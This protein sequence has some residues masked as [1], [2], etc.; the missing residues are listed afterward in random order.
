MVQAQCS[1]YTQVTGTVT[2]PNGVPW[3][4]GT[5]TATLSP[6]SASPTCTNGSGV[7]VP[8]SAQIGPTP[9]GSDGSFSLSL[10]P[11]SIITPGSTQWAFTFN[12]SG[13]APPFGKGPQTFS[14]TVTISG[15]SQ[16]IT[17]QIT[18]APVPSLTNSAG[19]GSSGAPNQNLIYVSSNCGTPAAKNCFQT[20]W[21][22]QHRV[23]A[24]WSNGSTTVNCADCAFT[25]SDVGKRIAGFS[26]C[27]AS[28]GINA[29]NSLGSQAGT[30]ISSVNS[31]T[32]AVV[33]NAA[34][35]TVS[36]NGCLYWGHPDDVAL[37]AADAAAQSSTNCPAISLPAGI[38]VATQPHFFIQ[39]PAC[40]RSPDLVGNA[41]TSFGFTVSGQGMQ[42]TR[43]WLT[44][45]FNLSG[46]RSTGCFLPPQSTFDG[47][48]LTGGGL[49]GNGVATAGPLIQLSVNA[50]LVDFGCL[51]LYPR[52]LSVVGISAQSPEFHS[53]LINSQIDGCGALGLSDNGTV[54]VTNSSIEDSY[55]IQAEISPGA[56][57][58]GGVYQASPESQAVGQVVMNVGGT[59]Y[60]I[61]TY[62]NG[63]TGQLTGYQGTLAS[64][65]RCLGGCYFSTSANGSSQALRLDNTSTAVLFGTAMSSGGLALY[66]T[67][68]T[69]AITDLGGN[70]VSSGAISI[71]SGTQIN[72]DASIGGV[73]LTAT[74][75]TPSS[76]WG[77]T[78]AAGNGVSSASGSTRAEVFTI[79]A[80]GTPTAN[81]TVAIVFPKAFWAAPS[82]GCQAS[83]IGGTGVISDVLSNTATATGVTLTWEGTPVSG[84]TYI[85]SVRCSNP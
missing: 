45:D 76:G 61:Q 24:T 56:A 12:I 66:T 16:S 22:G 32:Q 34:T 50:N 29:V 71:T 5:V 77:T 72:G 15:S 20:T 11:N 46:C 53:N 36:S 23:D 64:T 59:A 79:T 81:P 37:S 30:T 54:E 38:G 57:L 27:V 2:D 39:P 65:L 28:L 78:G 74:N 51:N 70:A 82:G 44:P 55:Q 69:T 49:S 73:A 47:W 4:T 31:S 80:A 10:P 18:A 8:F 13:V 25:A 43:L 85:F 58:N 42:V 52:A 35:G 68:S 60:N 62:P 63:M 75:V 7:P 67:A 6:T 3:S 84:S 40:V 17:T 48:T 21:D 33:S 41:F 26:T 19:G 9:L 1:S 14:V 83:Q